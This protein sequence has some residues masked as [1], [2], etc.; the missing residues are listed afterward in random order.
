MVETTWNGLL[1]WAHFLWLYFYFSVSFFF[2]HFSCCIWNAILKFTSFPFDENKPEKV[3]NITNIINVTV[4]PQ[5]LQANTHAVYSNSI[6]LISVCILF[7]TKKLLC[8]YRYCV[9]HYNGAKYAQVSV[10]LC[11]FRSL[12]LSFSRCIN[13]KWANTM[14]EMEGDKS[15]FEEQ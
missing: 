9:S 15:K 12:S 2:M 6:K 13:H 8:I 10:Y 11:E 14:C 5:L 3:Q 4:R 7:H 1:Q